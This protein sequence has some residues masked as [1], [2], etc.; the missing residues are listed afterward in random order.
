M[1]LLVKKV[2]LRLNRDEHVEHSLLITQQRKFGEATED[3]ED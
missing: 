1:F 2:A 3:G